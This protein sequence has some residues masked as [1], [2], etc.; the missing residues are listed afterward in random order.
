MCIY[1]SLFLYRSLHEFLYVSLFRYVYTNMCLFPSHVTSCFLCFTYVYWTI[2]LHTCIYC[3]SLHIFIPDPF[4][5]TF[6]F[7]HSDFYKSTSLSLY[8]YIYFST[9]LYMHISLNPM[10][11]SRL[12]YPHISLPRPLMSFHTLS[13]SFL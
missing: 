10:S 5:Y 2:Y 3:L 6:H 12:I 11:L 4:T 8:P 9:H 13:I 7:P 1:P